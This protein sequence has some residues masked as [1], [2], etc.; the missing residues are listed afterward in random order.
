MISHIL[1]GAAI[2]L[3]VVTAFLALCEVIDWTRN[4]RKR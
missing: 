1:S 2:F 4:G 3:G